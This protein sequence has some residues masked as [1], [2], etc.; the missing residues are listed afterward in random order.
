M[1]CPFV[2]GVTCPTYPNV[3]CAWCEHG[4]GFFDDGDEGSDED[5]DAD[6]D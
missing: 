2:P 1:D 6:F 5:Y 4:S 3:T